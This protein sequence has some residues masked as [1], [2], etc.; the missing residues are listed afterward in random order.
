MPTFGKIS[1]QSWKHRLTFQMAFTK[2]A[3]SIKLRSYVVKTEGGPTESHG[4]MFR[5][6]S[7]TI[8]LTYE[9]GEHSH[10]YFAVLPGGFLS[11]KRG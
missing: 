8:L 7:P 5:L 4:L 3:F 9:R 11:S 10:A 6:W 1:A 2:S